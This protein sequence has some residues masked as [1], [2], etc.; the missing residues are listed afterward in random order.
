M[1]IS[2]TGGDSQAVWRFTAT[3]IANQVKL[4]PRASTKGKIIGQ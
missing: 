1:L 3:N 4:N 2:A